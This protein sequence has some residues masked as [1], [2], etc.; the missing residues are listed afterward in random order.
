[1]APELLCPEIFK[2]SSSRPTQP[3][4]IYAFA[5]VIYEVLIGFQP[6]HEQKWGEFEIVYHVMTGVRPAKPADAW[7]IG[8][9][10]G[11][12]ELVETCWTE[13]PT[14]RPTIDQVLTHLTCIAA[15]SMVVG[16]TPGKPRVSDSTSKFF[17][18]R[19]V[20]TLISMTKV[21]YGRFHRRW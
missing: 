4:D 1:M 16:P 21:K 20:T 5:M 15:S 6:F 11:T 2:K 8:F 3:A 19:P 9:G 7:Q 12:W 10:N 14:K 17:M 18:S 13:E